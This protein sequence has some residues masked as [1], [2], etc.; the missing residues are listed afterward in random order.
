MRY[1]KWAVAALLLAWGALYFSNQSVLAWG[2]IEGED[3]K[4]GVFYAGTQPQRYLACYHFTGTG[5]IRTTYYLSVRQAC[6]R[7]RSLR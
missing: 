1:A 3:P 5:I 6:P 4:P 2:A 7:W